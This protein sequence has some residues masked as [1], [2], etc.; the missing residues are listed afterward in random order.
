MFSC[1]TTKFSISGSNTKAKGGGKSGGGKGGARGKRL[2]R[3][4]E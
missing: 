3:S 2:R 4:I 1:Q